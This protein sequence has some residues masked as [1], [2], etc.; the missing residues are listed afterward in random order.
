MGQMPVAVKIRDAEG[1]VAADALRGE[2]EGDD[3]RQMLNKSQ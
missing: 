1:R 2:V 3:G